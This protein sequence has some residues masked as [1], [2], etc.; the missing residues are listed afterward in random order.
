MP[1]KTLPLAAVLGLLASPSALVAEPATVKILQVNDWD[2]Y[3]EDEGR[4]GFARLLAVL[5]AEDAA[6][7]DV[8]FVHAGDALSPSLLSGFDRGAHMVALLNEMPLDVFVMGNHEFDFGPEVTR[9]RLAEAKFPV[10]NANVA[11]AD[12]TPF[13]GTA[14]SRMIGVGDYRLGFYGLTTPETVEISSPGGARFA[15]VLET[16]RAAGADPVVPAVRREWGGY[17]G[18]FADPD[19]YRWEIAFAPGEITELVVPR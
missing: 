8:L 14:E 19:G 1:R 17:S 7:K 5:E 9:E 4:G 3:A 2:R 12:G 10:L 13:P 18:Y 11:L 6:S 15:P 16:A